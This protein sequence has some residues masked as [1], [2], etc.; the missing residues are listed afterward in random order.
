MTHFFSSA[1]GTI[2]PV[3]GSTSARRG[4]AA[5]LATFV[6]AVAIA[7]MLSSTFITAPPSTR[8]P[9]GDLTD[10][11]LP[12]AIAANAAAHAASSQL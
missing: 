3:E 2:V 5:M 12:G 7:G 4:L 1:A 10:G 6:A 9:S 11:F 8:A